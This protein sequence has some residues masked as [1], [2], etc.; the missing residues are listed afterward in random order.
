MPP[1][2]A[3]STSERATVSIQ[4]RLSLQ[5]RIVSPQ[6][7]AWAWRSLFRDRLAV[8]TLAITNG[9]N[10]N[11]GIP[12]LGLDPIPRSVPSVIT[13]PTKSVTV[14]SSLH[15]KRL[16]YLTRMG[17]SSRPI[18]STRAWTMQEQLFSRRTLL[19]SDN[20]AAWLCPSTQ[21]LEEVER[22]SES[23]EWARMEGF[24]PDQRYDL[25]T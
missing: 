19:L 1:P 9:P 5:S 7:F 4:P 14:F 11:S 10:A 6:D 12:G 17:F 23:H 18:W 13:L 15:H 24:K 20:L 2:C 22:P 8:F 21:Y 25:S 16:K 3:S